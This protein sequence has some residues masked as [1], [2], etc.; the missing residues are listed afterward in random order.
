VARGKKIEPEIVD[1]V[2]RFT[3]FMRAGELVKIGISIDP[4]ARLKAIKTSNPLVELIGFVSGGRP[5]ETQLHQEF[6][7]IC[8]GGEWFKETP[9]LEKIIAKLLRVPKENRKAPEWGDIVVLNDGSTGLYDDNDDDDLCIVYPGRMRDGYVLVAYDE[10][11]VSSSHQ[12][13]QWR[14]KYFGEFAMYYGM[15]DAGLAAAIAL[16][17]AGRS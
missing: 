15:D 16:M 8:K 6:Y 14:S 2:E 12:A 17:D 7:K 4:H 13:N 9:E 3:Y 1:G 10:C 11:V 5:L